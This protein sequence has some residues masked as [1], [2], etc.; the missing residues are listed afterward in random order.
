MHGKPFG[1]GLDTC[2]HDLDGRGPGVLGPMNPLWLLSVFIVVHERQPALF[3]ALLPA[4][5]PRVLPEAT[6]TRPVAA[7]LFPDPLPHAMQGFKQRLGVFSRQAFESGVHRETN[8]GRDEGGLHVGRYRLLLARNAFLLLE[9]VLVDA[10]GAQDAVGA[11]DTGPSSRGRHAR[12]V[13]NAYS[14]RQAC[15]HFDVFSE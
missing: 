13:G 6:T 7:A 10:A 2:V 1:R 15:E 3:A 12:C 8:Q 9:I 4:P 11:F 14:L 5:L